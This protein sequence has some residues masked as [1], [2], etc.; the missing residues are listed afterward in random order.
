MIAT[1]KESAIA[2]RQLL[3]YVSVTEQPNKRRCYSNTADYAISNSRYTTYAW[4]PACLLTDL[5]T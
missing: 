5:P 2:S 1:D 4:L 3:L